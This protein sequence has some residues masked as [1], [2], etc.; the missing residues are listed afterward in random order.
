MHSFIESDV[1]D[2]D[3]SVPLEEKER[4]QRR[5]IRLSGVVFLNDTML[6]VSDTPDSINECTPEINSKVK[7][8]IL[9]VW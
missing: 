6:S 2:T 1:T 3:N 4:K 8:H 5:L 7:L 9:G